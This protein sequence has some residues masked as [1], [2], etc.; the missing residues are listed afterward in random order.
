MSDGGGGERLPVSVNV[1]GCHGS[2]DRTHNGAQDAG[3]AMQVVDA[4]RVLDLQLLLQDGLKGEEEEEEEEE[5]VVTWMSQMLH[6][7]F[8]F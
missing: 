4:A 3:H 5:E 8:F 6:L 7:L 2:G 1:P